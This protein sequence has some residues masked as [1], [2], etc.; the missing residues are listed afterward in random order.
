MNPAR[1]AGARPITNCFSHAGNLARK[2]PMLGWCVGVN[3]RSFV[4]NTAITDSYISLLAERVGFEPTVPFQA[5]RIS[6]A[7]LSTTQP[8]LQVFLA[9]L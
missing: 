9:G 7:V 2:S 8:P 3:C 5:R 6:S 4:N 1:S